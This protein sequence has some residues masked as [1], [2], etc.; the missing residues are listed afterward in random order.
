[1]ANP[2]L[3]TAIDVGTTKVCVV[4]G[5]KDG[6][7]DPEVLAYSVVPCEGLRKGIV[8]DVEATARAIRVAVADVQ[9]SVGVDIGSA[10]VGVTGAHIE[11]T[12]RTDTMDWVGQKGVISTDDMAL[13]PLKVAEA[14][15][16]PGRTIIHALST[17]YTLDGNSG[18]ISPVGM[19]TNSM[20]VTTHVISGA[21]GLVDMLMASVRQAEIE[22]DGLVLE[23]L[24]SG[25][26]VLHPAER[27]GVVALVDI[28]GG[29]TD[30]VVFR[31]GLPHYTTA[32]GVGGFHFTND[33]ALMYDTSYAT[34]ESVKL[35][36]AHTDPAGASAHE[37]ITI[38]VLGPARERRVHLHDIC[39]L[40][41]ER[42]AELAEIIKMKL[43]DAGIRNT[44]DARIV[45]TGGASLMPGLLELMRRMVSSNIR[46]GAPNGNVG[47]P[48]G[49][50][51]PSFSTSAGI[52]LW[53]ADQAE[54]GNGNCAHSSSVPHAN[55]NGNGHTNGNGNGKT[56]G[57]NGKSGAGSF[58][59][60][61]FRALRN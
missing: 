42:A 12:N 20:D 24:A 50:R 56:N 39:Q 15:E 35:E 52:L 13:V 5:V 60:R 54:S 61:P 29:T 27:Q 45:L 49:L 21:K 4:V 30:M 17:S 7:A 19:H 25:R 36:H 34:A 31:N 59:T 40:T 41:R 26:A 46:I 6:Y 11:F 32:I 3:I 51:A 23:P 28:G 33:I 8:Y 44:F 53:A 10:Y 37:E 48:D 2:R 57:A 16:V 47:M 14:A 58:F 22:V 43:I 1:M 55:G 18:I 38:Q 9:K